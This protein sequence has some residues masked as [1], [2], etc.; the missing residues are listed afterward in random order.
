MEESLGTVSESVNDELRL[1]IEYLTAENRILRQQI[2]SRVRLSDHD[3]K[4]LV[5]SV[6]R[7]V[8]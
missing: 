7:W 6:R 1:R 4:E 5:K 8:A 3:R 2:K